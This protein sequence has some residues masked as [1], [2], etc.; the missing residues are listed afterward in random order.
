MDPIRHL[1]FSIAALISIIAIGTFG[2]SMVEGWSLFDSLYMTVI[3]LATVGFKEVQPLSSEGKLFTIIL[4]ISGT[5]MIAYTLS[6]LLQFTMEGQLRKILG[7]KKLESRISKLREHYII[8]GFGRIGHLICREFHSRPLPFVVVEKDPQLIERVEREG[9]MFVE[10]DATD[11]ETLQAAGIDHALGLITAVTSDTDNVYITLTARG[12]NPK[13]FI[14]ARAGEEGSEKKLMRAG[15]SKVISP[16]TIGASRMAQAI[17]RPSVV[18]FIEIATASENIELQIEEI[19]VAANSSLAGKTLIDS[20]V[21]QSMGIIIVGIKQVDGQMIFNPPPTR[22][23]EPNATLIILGERT[24]IN[25]LEKIA[26][27]APL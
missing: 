2:Y 27:G 25:Q 19:P 13:L 17:L 20:G 15:A 10:G 23:I 22:V 1:R 6:S 26:G 24:A 7:R 12:L 18:D 4:I 5:G 11:D 3:T 16:Y 14:L 9:F 8:C 21:R